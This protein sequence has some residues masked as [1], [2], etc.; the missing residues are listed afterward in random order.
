MDDT[1]ALALAVLRLCD[2]IED[3]GTNAVARMDATNRARKHAHAVLNRHTPSAE[4]PDVC[5]CQPDRRGHC[6]CV[7]TCVCDENET[8]KG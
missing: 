3:G 8:E 5:L 4:T 2:A 6:T 7:G 1:S